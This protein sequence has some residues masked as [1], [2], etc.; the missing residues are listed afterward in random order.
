MKHRQKN[1][2]G[3]CACAHHERKKKKR[4]VSNLM[5]MTFYQIIKLY[6][7]LFRL[8]K[9]KQFDLFQVIVLCACG[10]VCFEKQPASHMNIM[11]APTK[12]HLL[13]IILSYSRSTLSLSQWQMRHNFYFI[14]IYRQFAS[15][16]RTT[17]LTTTKNSPARSD[18]CNQLLIIG[19][20]ERFGSFLL[21]LFLARLFL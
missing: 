18:I 7:I 6:Y 11:K 3:E 17:T 19:C 5:M 16:I 4:F 2:F 10:F 1:Y 14:Y 15:L 21:L 9:N 8:I 20:V 12:R 13:F